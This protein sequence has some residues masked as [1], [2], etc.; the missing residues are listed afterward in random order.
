MVK[1]MTL[2]FIAVNVILDQ[3]SLSDEKRQLST[4]ALSSHCILATDDITVALKSVFEV[5]SHSCL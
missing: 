3:N 5:N 1:V 4:P 2:I